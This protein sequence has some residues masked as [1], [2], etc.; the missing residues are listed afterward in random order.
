MNI[1]WFTW[2]DLDNPLAGGAEV[3]NEQLAKRLADDGHSVTFIVSGF[4]EGNRET[5]RSG[6]HIIRVGS[7]FT[8]YVAAWR[9]YRRHKAELAADLVIDECNTMPFFSGW[10]TGAPTFLFI[11]MLCRQI[12]FYEF[13]FP[14]GI[15]GWLSEPVYLR[16]L[17]R[18]PVITVSKSSRRDLIRTGFGSKTIHIISEGIECEPVSDLTALEKYSSPTILSFGSIRAMKRTLDQLKAFELAKTR[19]KDL[20][21][22]VAGDA[23]GKYGRKVLEAIAASPYAKDIDCRGHVTEEEKKQLMQKSHLLLATSVKEGWCLVVTEAASQGTPAVVYDADGLRD[24][25]QDRETGMVTTSNTPEVLAAT[26]ERL[27]VNP[28]L[29][30]ELRSDGWRRSKLVNF[31]NSYQEF[32]QVLGI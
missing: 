9:F 1:V 4:K 3:V 28:T 17:K 5:T 16:L 21:L 8:A 13:P 20:K 24:S 18:S 19:L 31:R 27:L 12:W 23:S 25:V 11:H 2:K 30:D 32:K 10:Y 7:R 14:L 26:I 22:I 15:I 29:Y 6:F